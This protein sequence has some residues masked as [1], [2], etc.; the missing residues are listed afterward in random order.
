MSGQRVFLMVKFSVSPHIW[1][2]L[3]M[4][5]RFG[6][7]YAVTILKRYLTPTSGGMVFLT[8]MIIAFYLDSIEILA[9]LHPLILIRAQKEV[10]N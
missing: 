8:P 3:L 1:N 6:V 4:K 7:I 10:S 9:L 5:V 2:I